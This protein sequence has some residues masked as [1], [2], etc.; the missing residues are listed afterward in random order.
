MKAPKSLCIL[1]LVFITT[2]IL[3]TYVVQL[4]LIQGDSMEPTYHS[5][6]ISFINKQTKNIHHGDVIVFYCPSYD[7]YL[8]KRVIGCPGDCVEIK[9][10]IV[11][12]NNLPSPHTH[13][14]IPITYAGT[15]SSIIT[16]DNNQ[17]FVLGDN[18]EYSKDSRYDEIG[19]IPRKDILG[20]IFPQRQIQQ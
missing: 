13:S 10:G 5:W 12:V 18:Y 6:E 3:S 17:Y 9:N 20:T 14:N 16:L 19:C 1:L 8:T 7:S 4:S 2:Y 11:Y 15:A